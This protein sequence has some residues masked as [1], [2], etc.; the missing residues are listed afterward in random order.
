MAI[1]EAI[2]IRGSALTE[3]KPAFIEIPEEYTRDLAVRYRQSRRWVGSGD[4]DK[5]EAV[6]HF[7][8]L[9]EA[10][11]LFLKLAGQRHLIEMPETSI[12]PL[13]VKPLLISVTDIGLLAN[14]Y[15][16]ARRSNVAMDV[17]TFENVSAKG[18]RK[19]A[20]M[21]EMA[22]I[23]FNIGQGD[24]LRKIDEEV[25]RSEA[26]LARE[27]EIQEITKRHQQH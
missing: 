24:L 5:D 2:E 8:G 4:P 10:R 9:T 3:P 26:D 21:V 14:F 11:E 22:S 25:G 13:I 19:H 17:E 18:M 16:N 6:A 27:K 7:T 23:L 20:Q 1:A 12:I 15:R